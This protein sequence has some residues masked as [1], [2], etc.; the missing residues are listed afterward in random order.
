MFICLKKKGETIWSLLKLHFSF[1]VGDLVGVM[2]LSSSFFA[3]NFKEI[4]KFGD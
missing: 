1:S 2:L 3:D 4:Q